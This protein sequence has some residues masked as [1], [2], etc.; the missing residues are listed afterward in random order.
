MHVTSF[1]LI[2][3]EY[4]KGE[5]PRLLQSGH[6]PGAVAAASKAGCKLRIALAPDGESFAVAAGI[7]LAQY[8]VSSGKQV[9]ALLEVYSGK[10]QVLTRTC[11]QHDVTVTEISQNFDQ[12]YAHVTLF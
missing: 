12:V 7:N 1:C 10:S 8:V 6:I 2:A 9:G 3:V 5:D 4:K 11:R